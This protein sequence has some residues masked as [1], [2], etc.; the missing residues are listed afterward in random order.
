M[1]CVSYQTG[2]LFDWWVRGWWW[3]MQYL[4]REEEYM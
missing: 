4:W 3:S 2:L 1:I